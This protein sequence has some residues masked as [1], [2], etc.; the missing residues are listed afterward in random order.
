MVNDFHKYDV[1][2]VF[3]FRDTREYNVLVP[4]L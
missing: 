2:V 3:A 1:R 4:V